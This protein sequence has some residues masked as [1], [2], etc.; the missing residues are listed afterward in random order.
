MHLLS[1]IVPNYNHSVFL[2]RCLNAVLDQSFQDYEIVIVDDGSTDDSLDVI[3]SFQNKF[4]DKIRLFENGINRGI[5]PTVNR[6]IEVCRGEYIVF[7]S[8]DDV[9][10]PGYFEEAVA[11]L[12]R[13][14][15][16]G[17][18]AT[19][20]YFY[21]EDEPTDI[22][23]FKNTHIDKPTFYDPIS[24]RE[25]LRKFNCFIYGA[26]IILKKSSVM[27]CGGYHDLGACSDWLV[28]FAIAFRDGLCILPKPFVLVRQSR[29]SFSSNAPSGIAVLPK[30]LELLNGS[31]KDVKNAFFDSQIV[32]QLGLSRRHIVKCLFVPGYHFQFFKLGLELLMNSRQRKTRDSSVVFQKCENAELVQRAR[33]LK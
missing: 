32:L 12:K 1:V 25:A 5:V 11:L 10:L 26:A 30:V 20:Q 9:I 13:Y 23:E 28:V 15:N 18:C 24:Y 7:L 33:N 22:L 6:A 3:R 27:R 16:A 31:F 8:A 14:P 19:Y 29:N 2:S 21:K 4:P 17:G